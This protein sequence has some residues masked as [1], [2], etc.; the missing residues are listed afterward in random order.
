MKR[1]A[2][3][4]QEGRPGFFRYNGPELVKAKQKANTVAIL[5]RYNMSVIKGYDGTEREEK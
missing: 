2:G 3:L 4:S 5:S 1:A